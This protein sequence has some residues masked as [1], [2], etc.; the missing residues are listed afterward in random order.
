MNKCSKCQSEFEGDVCP[1]CGEELSNLVQK[2]KKSG[3]HK[4]LTYIPLIAFTIFVVLMGIMMYKLPVAVVNLYDL[5]EKFGSVFNADRF[6]EIA[7][8]SALSAIMLI[9]YVV[10]ILCFVLFLLFRTAPA[11]KYTKIFNKPFYKI[12]EIVSSVL[13]LVYLVFDFV[14]IGQIK[15]ANH[16]LKIIKLGSYPILS[17][18]LAF[19]CLVAIV[20]SLI[21]CYKQEKANPEIMKNWLEKRE[22]A[23][24]K[25]KTSKNRKENQGPVSKAIS[26]VIL[27]GFVLL[28][29]KSAFRSSSINDRFITDKSFNVESL[30]KLLSSSSSN[31]YVRD[32]TARIG[33]ADEAPDEIPSSGIYDVTYYTNEYSDLLKQAKYNQKYLA[34]AIKSGDRSRV[35]EILKRLKDLEEEQDVLVYGKLEIEYTRTPLYTAS[36]VKK[37]AYNSMVVNDVSLTI[38]ELENVNVYKVNEVTTEAGTKKIESIT[39]LAKYSDGSFIYATCENVNVVLDNGGTSNTYEGSYANKTFKWNDEF[40]TYEKVI[41][42]IYVQK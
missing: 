24:E 11:Y 39:Y 27:V 5:N 15:A 8:L 12:M 4:I 25:A 34:S 1:A 30:E 21:L 40:G 37:A 23:K 10:V 42:S 29:S 26:I 32:I 3:F 2:N 31:I 22:Q 18:I 19:V 6:D 14:M 36:Y 35:S 13:V 17:T 41:S 9:G 20:G 28:G 33:N 16:G 38:K 7:G